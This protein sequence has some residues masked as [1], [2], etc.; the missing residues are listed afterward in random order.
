MSWQERYV[1]LLWL[2]HLMLA[3]FELSSISAPEEAHLALPSAFTKCKLPPIAQLLMKTA[4]GHLYAAS[5]ER[6]AASIVIVRLALRGDM[7]RLS[8]P[9]AIIDW[10]TTQLSAEQNYAESDQYRHVG[11]LTL[12]YSIINSASSQEAV[13]FVADTFALC[14]LL[15]TD[16]SPGALA[17]RQAAPSRKLLIK[18]LRAS[19]LHM[20]A[21]SVAQCESFADLLDVSLEQGIQILLEWLSDSDTPV[22]QAASKALGAIILQLPVDMGVDVVDALLAC[23]DENILLEDRRTGQLTIATD[24]INID[25]NQY[26]KNLNAVD[27]LKWHGAMLALGHVLFRRSAPPHQLSAI[28]DALILGLNFE[29]RSNVGTSLGVSV[30]D[31]ACFGL[32]SLARKYATNEIEAAEISSSTRITQSSRDTGNLNTIR[33]IATELVLS[34]CLDPSGNLRRGSSAAL[35]ELIGRHPDVIVSGISVVQQV[36][37]HAVARRSRAILEVSNAV[38]NLGAVYH[39]GLLYGL[40]GWRGCRAVDVDSRCQAAA[41]V[42]ILFSKANLL[43]QISFSQELTSQIEDL[44][45]VNVGSNAATRHGLL[46]ILSEILTLLP[47]MDKGLNEI[48]S[49]LCPVLRRTETVTGSLS[50]KVT[51]DLSNVLEAIAGYIAA[52]ATVFVHIPS[53]VLRSKFISQVIPVLDRC[54]TANEDSLLAAASA[55]ANEAV[56]KLLTDKQRHTLLDSWIPTPLPKRRSESMC[57]GRIKSLSRLFSLLNSSCQLPAFERRIILFLSSIVHS[58]LAIDLRVSAMEGLSEIVKSVAKS[59]IQSQSILIKV[60]SSG[61]LDYTNDQRGDIGSLLRIASIDAVESISK[62]SWDSD[63]IVLVERVARLAAERLGKVRSLAWTCLRDWERES[64]INTQVGDRFQHLADFSSFDYFRQVAD[65]L[66]S[67]LLRGQVLSGFVTSIVGGGDDIGL[68]SSDA[69]IAFLYELPIDD[70]GK[71][72]QWMMTFILSELRRLATRD[73]REVVPW[74]VT[75][76]VIF[77]QFSTDFDERVDITME[78]HQI[79]DVINALQNSVADIQRIEALIRLLSSLSRMTSLKLNAIDLITRKLLHKWPKVRQAAVEAI[80][81]LDEKAIPATVDWS[82][83]PIQNKT[84]VV[85]IRKAVGVAGVTA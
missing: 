84:T 51:T 5:K 75:L 64:N 28:H 8:L 22:R 3:P 63:T 38:S 37:Y 47:S 32:W 20:V 45:S 52:E 69:L 36:D 6:E 76:C 65:L 49:V 24:L 25:M 73:D 17:A 19:L 31:A 11:L 60:I 61:L 56:F 44:R 81:M 4:L 53:T 79:L 18:S 2:S 50:G 66:A 13:L 72:L 39:I 82:L 41:A 62:S 68:V 46:L 10:C 85:A 26:R 12:L 30:R 21:L 71:Q 42:G 83:V 67:P 16:D 70:R 7:Q 78:N 33:I 27:P 1:M 14:I 9:S 59:D 40:L 29:Q 15:A 58:E 48:W 57:K 80:F 54:T 77:E 34:S 55:N 43:V 23:L 74:L 35:Q